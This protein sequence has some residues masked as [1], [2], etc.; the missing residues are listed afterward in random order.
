MVPVRDP[1]GRVVLSV[2]IIGFSG[3]EEPERL[4]QCLNRLESAA[5]RATELLAGLPPV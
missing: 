1:S 4:L 5:G 2:G 3:D